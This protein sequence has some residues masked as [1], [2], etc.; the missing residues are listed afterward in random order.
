MAGRTMTIWAPANIL[1]VRTSPD[2]GEFRRRVEG[3]RRKEE[4]ALTTCQDGGE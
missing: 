3:P 2:V 1:Q 4:E